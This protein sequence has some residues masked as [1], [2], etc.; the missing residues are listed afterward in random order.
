MA[1]QDKYSEYLAAVPR[2]SDRCYTT[3]NRPAF[4]F[5]SDLDAIATCDEY[6]FNRLLSKYLKAEPSYVEAEYINTMEDFARVLSYFAIN[7]LGGEVD[8]ASAEVV[9]TIKE[10]F[11]LDY[12][13]GGTCAQST[14]ALGAMGV[15]V[16]THFTDQSQ[17]VI[18]CLPYEG[19]E[20]IKDGKRVPLK[21]CVSG[22]L[23]LMHFIM[24]FNKGDVLNINGKKV[25]IP[26]SNR[27]IMEFDKVHKYL[28]V[29][30]DFLE[31]VE[32]NAKQI[33]SYSVSGF[34]AILDLEIMKERAAQMVEHFKNIKKN[35]PNLVIYF[36]SAHYISTQIRDYL[37]GELCQYMDIFGM[38]EEE[39]VHLTSKMEHPV[40][41]DDLESII[42]GLDYVLEQYPAK[43][44][45]MHSKD[46]SLYY[47]KEL[48]GVNIEMGL[49]LGNLMS[50]TKARVGHYGSQ[51]E[52]MVNLQLDLSSVGVEFAER[53]EN[54]DTK[55]T[56]VLVPSRYMEKPNFTIGL[57]DTFVAGVQLCFVK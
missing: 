49:T 32:N 27:L 38:N 36:E 9:E 46:Y 6:N 25:E 56:A 31:Y 5:T 11:N 45:I 10:Y 39:L 15:P 16:L 33:Y 48:K 52:C 18:D 55:H 8:I 23:P 7:G 28:P 41:K 26:L 13:L 53:L 50:G 35:N 54:M 3:G 4:A 40:D 20:S 29:R 44:I 57:G 43:G 22:E 42:T 21:E 34:N 1:Y 14:G 51:E 2:I 12:A 19:I 37:Y 17:E 24:Q 30:Q 47:G